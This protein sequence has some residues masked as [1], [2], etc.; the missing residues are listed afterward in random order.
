MGVLVPLCIVHSVIV[1]VG[2]MP[3]F[4]IMSVCT[5]ITLMFVLMLMLMR[6]FMIVLMRMFMDV[7]HV[8]MIVLMT[9]FVNVFMRMEMC[10]FMGSFHLCTS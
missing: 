6:V 9:V 5:D 2:A 3:M 10:V 7:A 4:V 1:I 8:T